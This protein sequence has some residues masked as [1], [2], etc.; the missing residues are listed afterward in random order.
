[1]SEKRGA[2][3]FDLSMKRSQFLCAAGVAAASTALAGAA[4]VALANEAADGEA[5][6]YETDVVVCGCGTS[7]APAAIAAADAGAQVIVIEKMDWLGGEMRRCGGGVAGAG[8]K[9]QAALGVEDNADDFYDYL[10]AI[11]GSEVD[12]DMV[13]VVADN[14]APTVDWIIDD[15]GGQPVDQWHFC[16]GDEG[17]ENLMDAGLNIGTDPANYTDNGMTPIARCHW[18]DADPD[19]PFHGDSDKGLCTYPGGTGLWKTFEKAIEVREA[20]QTMTSTALV[21]FVSDESGVTGVVA[22]QDGKQVRIKANK[23]VV[24]ATGNWGSNHEMMLNYTGHDF[25]ENA[26]GGLG[27]DIAGENDGSGVKAALALGCDL[28]FPYVYPEGAAIVYS[29]NLGGLKGDTETRAIDV[30]GE[31]IPHLFV[32]SMALGGV[33]GSKYPLC[34]ISVVRN[35]LFGR[36][37]GE[38]AAAL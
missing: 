15:L 1:M 9:V 19:D 34:G 27:L 17:L 14:A 30:N 26:W 18:F 20:I 8:T 6:D 21:S 25:E 23:G 31:V 12:P 2:G 5:W 29:W 11:G 13:R 24:L 35:I 33:L 16:G 22:E 7:G 10:M 38:Q 32:A 28:K 37:A 36:I 3:M 4:H